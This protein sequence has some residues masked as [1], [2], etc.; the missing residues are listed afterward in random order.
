MHAMC[1]PTQET[2]HHPVQLCQQ[3][4]RPL[5]VIVNTT[6]LLQIIHPLRWHTTGLNRGPHQPPTTLCQW[7]P[8]LVFPLLITVIPPTTSPLGRRGPQTLPS[9][10]QLQNP[11]KKPNWKC[12]LVRVRVENPELL[13]GL[14]KQ[15]N[16]TK[17][18]QPPPWLERGKVPMVLIRVEINV[19]IHVHIVR[20]PTIGITTS[21][22]I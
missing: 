14:Q 22:D 16:A 17:V 1:T 5:P 2:P 7:I 19:F 13:V 15:A 12:R 20:D 10:L 18:V 6:M 9:C 11:S 21:T 4:E 8:R 3:Q